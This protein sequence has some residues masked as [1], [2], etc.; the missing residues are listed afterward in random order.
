[1]GTIAFLAGIVL[2]FAGV[3]AQAV[4][5][6]NMK[7]PSREYPAAIALGAVI[8]LLIFALGAIPVAD[9]VPYAKISVQAGV[10]D[11]FAT[12]ISNL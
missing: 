2:L 1:M 6:M 10:F 12:V 5:V 3:E 8:A 11:T 9:I 4:F 7:N